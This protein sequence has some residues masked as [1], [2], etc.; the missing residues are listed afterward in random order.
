[1]EINQRAIT[2]KKKALKTPRRDRQSELNRRAARLPSKSGAAPIVINTNQRIIRFDRRRLRPSI[3]SCRPMPGAVPP[4]ASWTRR[5]TSKRNRVIRVRQ[6]T[7]AT[8][9]V[10]T[11]TYYAYDELST[12]AR[13]THCAVLVYIHIYGN[14]TIY[15]WFPTLVVSHTMPQSPRKFGGT[16]TGRDYDFPLPRRVSWPYMVVYIY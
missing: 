2:F 14:S 15:A 16:V 4:S 12:H 6:T 10:H 7:Y 8:N 1:M 13:V 9:L 5:P 3:I 11:R